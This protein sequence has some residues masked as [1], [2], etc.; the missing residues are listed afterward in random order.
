MYFKTHLYGYAIE[1]FAPKNLTANYITRNDKFMARHFVFRRENTPLLK[2]I[3][4]QNGEFILW[5]PCPRARNAHAPRNNWNKWPVLS[6]NSFK[7]CWVYLIINQRPGVEYASLLIVLINCHSLFQPYISD[8][9]Q[10]SSK[11]NFSRC[12]K[13]RFFCWVSKSRDIFAAKIQITGI[14]KIQATKICNQ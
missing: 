13:I 8:P 6:W 14:I 7:P 9:Q 1:R 4:P 12:T 10:K 3:S 5:L 2:I 11:R